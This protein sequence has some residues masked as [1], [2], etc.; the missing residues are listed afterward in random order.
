MSFESSDCPP[1]EPPTQPQNEP[2]APEPNFPRPFYLEYYLN[3]LRTFRESTQELA[4]LLRAQ[5]LG[6]VDIREA[7]DLFIETISCAHALIELHIRIT[8]H[9]IRPQQEKPR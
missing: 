7:S 1:P 8:P 4:E 5:P 6:T 9:K 3:G 2:P